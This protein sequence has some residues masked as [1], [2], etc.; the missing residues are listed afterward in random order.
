MYD[1]LARVFVCDSSTSITA[2]IVTNNI[3]SKEQCNEYTVLLVRMPE[4][5][6]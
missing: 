1:G 5:Q 2:T 3:E 6:S 4:L